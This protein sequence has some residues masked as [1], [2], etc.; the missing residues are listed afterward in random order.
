MHAKGIEDNTASVH[1]LDH[2]RVVRV[3]VGTDILGNEKLA[4]FLVERHLT[5]DLIGIFGNRLD[6][7]PIIVSWYE[8]GGIRGVGAAVIRLRENRLLSKPYST[9]RSTGVHNK[10][11][12]QQKA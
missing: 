11:N 6:T 10:D 3:E 1:L 2:R 8:E 9:V 12:G 7:L 4:Q 5:D